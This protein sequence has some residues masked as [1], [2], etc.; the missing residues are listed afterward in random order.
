M[1]RAILFSISCVGNLVLFCVLAEVKTLPEWGAICLA[2]FGG[3]WTLANI[4]YM[5][6]LIWTDGEEDFFE[7]MRSCRIERSEKKKKS[8]VSGA[9]EAGLTPAAIRKLHTEEALEHSSPVE[10]AADAVSKEAPDT[11]QA[12]AWKNWETICTY[13]HT[14]GYHLLQDTEISLSVKDF[15]WKAILTYLSSKYKAHTSNLYIYFVVKKGKL[16]FRYTYTHSG[17]LDRNKM[18]FPEED[19]ASDATLMVLLVQ[20]AV[21]QW[22]SIKREL[23]APGSLML[24]F[25]S[26]SSKNKPL[27]KDEVQKMQKENAKLRKENEELQ[28]K[29]EELEATLQEVRIEKAKAEATIHYASERLKLLGGHGV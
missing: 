14:Y 29:K 26:F 28:K 16:G 2:V 8:A 12:L 11:A 17:F 27:T 23:D 6:V 20:C 18:F 13:F 9:A 1:K 21:D 7:V 3:V 5:F 4:G 19:G 24:E 22:T 15:L 25:R 10:N